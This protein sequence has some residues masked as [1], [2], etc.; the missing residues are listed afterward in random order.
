MDG[1]FTVSAVE[2]VNCE[3]N[4]D[5][6]HTLSSIVRQDTLTFINI[7]GAQINL[8]RFDLANAAQ[9]THVKRPCP[10]YASVRYQVVMP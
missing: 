10:V 4:V 9:F 2:R 6:V 5:S 3:H 7:Y 8:M 1:L